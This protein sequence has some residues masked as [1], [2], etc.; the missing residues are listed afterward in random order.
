MDNH[1]TDV[2]S[3]ARSGNKQQVLQFLNLGIDIESKNSQRHSILMIAAY[4]GHYDLAEMLIQK[5]ADVNSVDAKGNSILMGIVFK[6][7]GPLF[8]LFANSGANLEYIN[9]NGQ[10]ALDL[11]IMFGKRDL[12]F[13]IN[14]RLKTKRSN[15]RLEQAKTWI[16]YIR[17]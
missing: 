11:A 4:N 3:A 7:Y 16:Q 12:I 14:Q 5:K 15:S 1:T 6:G 2:Y 13:K 10:S 17:S 8:D 9:P